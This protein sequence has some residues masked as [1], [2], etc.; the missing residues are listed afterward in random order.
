MDG[1]QLLQENQALR[2]RV[3]E[4]EQVSAERQS[5]QNALLE[6]EAHLRLLMEQLPVVVWATDTDLRFTFSSGAGLKHLN[7]RPNQVVG[8]SLFEFFHTTDPEFPIIAPIRQALRG[9][10]AAF[11]AEW[12]GRN[13][14]CHVQPLRLPD[15]T[16]FGSIG[17]AFDVTERKQQEQELR[18]SN[19]RIEMA[20]RAVKGVIFD[21]DLRANTVRRSANLLTVVGFHPLEADPTAAWWLERIHPEDQE[22]CRQAMTSAYDDP[23]QTYWEC[24][25]RVLHKDGRYVHVWDHALIKR[26][27]E[28]RALRIVGSCFDITRRIDA[29]QALRESEERLCQA[30]KMEAIGRLAGGVA[31]DFNNLLTGITGYAELLLSTLTSDDPRHEHAFQITTAA[32]Q[33]APLTRQLLADEV[34]RMS[35]LSRQ[36]AKPHPGLLNQSGSRDSAAQEIMPSRAARPFST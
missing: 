36:Q 25:Y 14:E 33:A 19:E 29:E 11:E 10:S 18:Q 32:D 26:D 30:Q 16:I 13:Y 4:L 7:L 8:T 35:G 9:Q 1:E 28:G 6:R 23:T 31:H 24:E 17:I 34:F 27:V 15:G 3:A 22:R 2:E 21:V 5:A 20:T 12:Y